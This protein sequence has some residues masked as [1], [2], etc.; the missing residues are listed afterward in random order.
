MA[1]SR[2]AR[3][4]SRALLRLLALA[5]G[6]S[7]PGVPVDSAIGA[8]PVRVK[9]SVVARVSTF[10]RMQV[11]HQADTLTV[12]AHD[13]ARG[14]LEVPAA[15]AFTVTT[16]AAEGYAIDFHPR[17]D[18]FSSVFVT[19]LPDPVE[20]GAHGGTATL[21]HPHGRATSHQLSYRFILRR[22]LAPGRYPW[23]LQMAVH[24]A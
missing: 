1:H 17:S 8:E 9:F 6:G 15:S 5:V 19:G 4:A 18:V 21:D 24:L 14:Y 12:T 23:P 22:D 3:K 16:N 7:G 2:I 10:F 11:E 20:I 13:V